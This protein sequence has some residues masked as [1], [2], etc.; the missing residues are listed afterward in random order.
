MESLCE[1]LL[2]RFTSASLSDGLAV[3]VSFSDMAKGHNA[4][5]LI[6]RAVWTSLVSHIW[7]ERCNRLYGAPRLSVHDLGNMV[8]K[9]IGFQ[10]L[11]SRVFSAAIAKI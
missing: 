2:G 11:G 9:E 10:A 1:A 6:A 3:L 4:K 7:K 8:L 5:G